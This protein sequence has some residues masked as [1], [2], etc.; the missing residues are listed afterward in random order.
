MRI[1]G[2]SERKQ[3]SAGEQLWVD[4]KVVCYTLQ[5]GTKKCG[6]ELQVRHN[7]PVIDVDWSAQ[8]EGVI[9]ETFKKGGQE[10]RRSIQVPKGT[11]GHDGGGRGS[12]F[13]RYF[14]YYYDEEPYMLTVDIWVRKHGLEWHILESGTVEINAQ[15]CV[16]Q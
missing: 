8:M 6:V 10:V 11:Y 13:E 15:Q 16:I 5:D 9:T 14:S 4:R 3:T 1:E 2:E 12:R 7:R